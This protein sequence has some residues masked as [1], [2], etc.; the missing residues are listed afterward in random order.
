MGQQNHYENRI[1]IQA[2]EWGDGRFGEIGLVILPFGE[3]YVQNDRMTS[4]D[5]SPN[6]QLNFLFP[7]T[8]ARIFMNALRGTRRKDAIKGLMGI[9]FTSSEIEMDLRTHFLSPPENKG[10]FRTSFKQ[11]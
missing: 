6:V 8:Q 1:V 7:I 4:Y 9:P 11:I 10:T 3:S 5:R 2:I